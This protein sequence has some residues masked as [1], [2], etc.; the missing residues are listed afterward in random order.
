MLLCLKTQTETEIKYYQNKNTFDNTFNIVLSNDNNNDSNIDINSDNNNND[1]INPYL[2]DFVEQLKL[3]AKDI[4]DQK[5][6]QF[7]ENENI[8]L[9]NFENELNKKMLSLN[10]YTTD[11]LNNMYKI[12]ETKILNNVLFLSNLKTDLDKIINDSTKIDSTDVGQFIKNSKNSNNN[13]NFSLSI[14]MDH[15]GKIRVSNKLTLQSMQISDLKQSDSNN[16]ANDDIIFNYGSNE[17]DINS[18]DD[19]NDG[20][21]DVLFSFDDDDDDDEDNDITDVN[22]LKSKQ[23]DLIRIDSDEYKNDD[24]KI[25]SRVVSLSTPMDT[26]SLSPQTGSTNKNNNE[27][28]ASNILKSIPEMKLNK[29]IDDRKEDIITTN[30]NEFTRISRGRSDGVFRE[31]KMPDSPTLSSLKLNVNNYDHRKR[32]NNISH[33][34]STALSIP[35]LKTKSKLSQSLMRTNILFENDNAFEPNANNN[36]GAHASKEKIKPLTFQPSHFFVVMCIKYIFIIRV[37]Y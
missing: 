9:N 6:Q 1:D 26:P 16:T 2:Y 8:K 31:S 25:H 24:E 33:S 12:N 32:N 14:P 17:L 15:N 23:K 22:R 37:I 7:I 19:D 5:I 11:K 28:R 27:N 21:I 3:N 35:N 4:S 10:K 34:V 20:N 13:N 30:G 18:D 36:R 29:L